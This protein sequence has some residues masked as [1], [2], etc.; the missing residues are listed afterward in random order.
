MT[1]AQRSRAHDMLAAKGQAVTLTRQAAGAYNPATGAATITPTTQAGKGVILPLSA[2]R[3]SLGN[4]VEGDAQLLL[5][6]LTAGGTVLTEPE[7]A[8]TV[9][10]AN[11]DV[12]TITGYEPLAPAGLTIIYDAIVRRAE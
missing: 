11:G 6:G 10:D 9:T 2:F 8:D 1:I 12:W 5:S 7:V 3:K 4:V